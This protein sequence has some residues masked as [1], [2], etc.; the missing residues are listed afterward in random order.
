MS[1]K[2]LLHPQTRESYQ[3]PGTLRTKFDGQTQFANCAAL[4]EHWTRHVSS[5]KT[6]NRC[7]KTKRKDTQRIL[8]VRVSGR[9]SALLDSAGPFTLSLRDL[10]LFCRFLAKR[11]LLIFHKA[12]SLRLATLVLTAV[13][14]LQKEL[15]TLLFFSLARH[16][17]Q[18][19]GNYIYIA[20]MY[21]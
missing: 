14:A 4:C 15:K 17:R 3:C 18:L 6:L 2:I 9:E 20:S 1:V 8:E 11:A 19:F 12:A 10:T 5:R 13:M 7:C 21:T 16:M